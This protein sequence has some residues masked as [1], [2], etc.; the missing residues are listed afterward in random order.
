MN[1][2]FHITFGQ[3]CKELSRLTPGVTFE[4]TGKNPPKRLD[5]KNTALKQQYSW[6]AA[7]SLLTDLPDEYHAYKASLGSA[8]SHGRN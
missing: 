2:D 5:L 3:L 7:V 1:D 4:F 6:F 8:G